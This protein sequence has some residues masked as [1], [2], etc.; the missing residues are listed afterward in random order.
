MQMMWRFF[1]LR[2]CDTCSN[3]GFSAVNLA[4]GRLQPFCIDPLNEKNDPQK[5]E[6]CRRYLFLVRCWWQ[7]KISG[8]LIAD[9]FE[10]RTVFMEEANPHNPHVVPYDFEYFHIVF[11]GGATFSSHNQTRQNEARRKEYIL[12]CEVWSRLLGNFH[13]WGL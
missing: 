10:V 8:L 13:E 3:D 6:S 2:T 12:Y 7:Y 5:H 9:W 1:L 11:R 4:G